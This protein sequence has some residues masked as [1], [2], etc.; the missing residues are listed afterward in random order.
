[1]SDHISH[2]SESQE[3]PGPSRDP[4]DEI[5]FFFS[6]TIF[7]SAGVAILFAFCGFL[8]VAAVFASL[9]ILVY[10]TRP[11]PAEPAVES[12]LTEGE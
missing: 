4:R 7:V 9:S 2:T 12:A 8:A 5:H 3:E 1:M 10:L 6:V 11:L